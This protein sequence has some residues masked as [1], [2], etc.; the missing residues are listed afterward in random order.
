MAELR[1][2]PECRRRIVLGN[3]KKRTCAQFL[4]FPLKWGEQGL[5]KN[6]EYAMPETG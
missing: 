5:S 2:E 6:A 1:W 4:S 3:S